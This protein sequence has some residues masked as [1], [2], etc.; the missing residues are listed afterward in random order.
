MFTPY[1]PPSV[2]G[3][4][5]LDRHVDAFEAIFQRL[6]DERVPAEQEGTMLTVETATDRGAE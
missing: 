3:L 5:T 6:V 1:F 4:E 2:A